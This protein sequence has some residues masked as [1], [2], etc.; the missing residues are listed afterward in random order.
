M[1]LKTGA[2]ST[3]SNAISIGAGASVGQ[4]GPVVHLGTKLG[5]DVAEKLHLGR[6]LARTLLGC[7][8]ASTV[9]ASF[10]APIAGW[11]S[12]LEVVVGHY[13]LGASA[14]GVILRHVVRRR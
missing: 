7:G 6:S 14:P 9:A 11:F 5:A 12:A 4:E 1:D 13:A 10:D 2:L 8:I 3:L